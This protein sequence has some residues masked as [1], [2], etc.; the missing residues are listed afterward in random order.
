MSL[1]LTWD[2]AGQLLWD[3]SISLVEDGV[4]LWLRILS[5]QLG[6]HPTNGI[7]CI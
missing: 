4:S 7:L 1:H 6:V 2:I 5:V 3:P